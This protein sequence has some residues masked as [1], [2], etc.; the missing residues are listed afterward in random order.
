MTKP[1]LHIK[2]AYPRGFCAGV[3]RAI[4][5]VEKALEKYGAPVYVRHEIVHNRFVVDSLKEK[6]AIFVEELHEIPDSAT[7][8]PVIY[9]AHGVS[10]EVVSEGKKRSFFT[11]DAT[12]PLVDKVHRQAQV[13]HSRGLQ[14]IMI[15]HRGH[16]EVAGTMGQVPD[17]EVLLIE[18]AEEVADLDVRDENK[19][20]LITQTTLSV[21]ETAETIAAVK[22]RF[23]KIM[24]PRK[25]DIC[26]AT[27]NRQAAVKKIAPD[28]DA[29]LIVGSVNS[30]NTNRL[31]DAALAAGCP[32]AKR[33]DRA[34]S[35]EW[36]WFSGVQTL[37]I[38]SGASVP[39]ILID[40]IITAMKEH[41]EITQEEV[42]LMDDEGMEFLLP[43]QL[44]QGD[45]A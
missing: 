32:K 23:P 6:G 40:D 38:S 39:D 10:K 35:L 28:V 44:E 9:S 13:Y 24:E 12:C 25:Q 14:M 41:Y 3:D 20:A 27:T 1:P 33:F 5:T 2:L 31:V 19:L 8:R 16:P 37:G 30:S 26:Y 11:L 18:T 34:S 42:R 7:D 22:K 36:A 21:D 45:A 4:K 43:R 17:G 15:G 29:F